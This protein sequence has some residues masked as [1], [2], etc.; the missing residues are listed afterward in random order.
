MS[1]CML[2]WLDVVMGGVVTGDVVNRR[3]GKH[4]Y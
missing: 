4:A 3:P 2:K 1:V